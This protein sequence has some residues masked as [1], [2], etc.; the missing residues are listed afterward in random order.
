V[1]DATQAAATVR[2]PRTG[3]PL[4]IRVGVHS[5]RVMSG[6]VGSIRARYCLFGDTVNTASRM[7]ST[8]LPGQIQVR[9]GVPEAWSFT[10][11]APFKHTGHNSKLF[12]SHHA[13]A[14]GAAKHAGRMSCLDHFAESALTAV[15]AAITSKPKL[16][17]MSDNVARLNSM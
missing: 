12:L 3:S 4:N 14:A 2:D 5:G 11:Q 7:E 15:L 8:G 6:V 10:V 16:C 9:G 13:F 1:W 17:L